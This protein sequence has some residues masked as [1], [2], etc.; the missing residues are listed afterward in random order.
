[1]ESAAR[2]QVGDENARRHW[3]TI[4]LGSQPRKALFGRKPERAGTVTD[5]CVEH[6]VRQAIGARKVPDVAGLWIETVHAVTRPGVYP[7]LSVLYEALD[8]IAREALSGAIDLD[9]RV[10]VAGVFY[11]A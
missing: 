8:N 1:M 5:G 2:A 11:V 9:P 3:R 4:R 6:C 10:R 7:A